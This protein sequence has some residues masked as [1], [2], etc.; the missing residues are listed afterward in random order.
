MLKPRHAR[1]LDRRDAIPEGADARES[2][3]YEDPLLPS[4]LDL[5][6]EGV[7]GLLDEMLDDL[8]AQRK[9]NSRAATKPSER[10]VKE[11]PPIPE[12]P[13]NLS[14]LPP[15]FDRIKYGNVV[16]VSASDLQDTSKAITRNTS[17]LSEKLLQAILPLLLSYSSAT[18]YT[19]AVLKEGLGLDIAF[20]PGLEEVVKHI[21]YLAVTHHFVRN[22]KLPKSTKRIYL[23][24]IAENL[25]A[26]TV[27]RVFSVNASAAKS[28]EISRLA[29][30]VRKSQVDRES[31]KE[32]AAAPTNPIASSRRRSR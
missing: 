18:N 9:A 26:K 14:N 4:D 13:V 28:A 20:D 19:Q 23:D 25:S 3:P 2:L 30:I 21:G 5:A 10:P 29:A 15:E 1:K 8:T 6:P 16:N 32:S 17:V 24:K 11:E 27:E 12:I 7:F 31:G 22:S